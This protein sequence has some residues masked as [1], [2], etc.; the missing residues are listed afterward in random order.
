MF[1]CNNIQLT[2]QK[3]FFLW[4]TIHNNKKKD[5]KNEVVHYNMKIAT[6]QKTHCCYKYII[7]QSYNIKVN[8]TYVKWVYKDIPMICNRQRFIL[9]NTSIVA[10]IK[11]HSIWSHKTEKLIFFQ[12]TTQ[13]RTTSVSSFRTLN[14]HVTYKT[15]SIGQV[16]RNQ[17]GIQLYHTV[18]FRRKSD[19]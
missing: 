15:N 1:F 3:W 8:C 9:E 5:M 17:Y 19:N 7:T 6:A 11:N 14:R 16:W 18:S 12:G 4:F 10:T 13:R 2:Q